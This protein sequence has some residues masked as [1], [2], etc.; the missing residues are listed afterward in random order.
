[1]SATYIAHVAAMKI[2]SYQSHF[3]EQQLV[4]IGITVRHATKKLHKWMNKN[5]NI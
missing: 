5:E 1:M 3:Q 2:I 4:P